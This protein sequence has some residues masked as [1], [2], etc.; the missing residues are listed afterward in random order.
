VYGRIALLV[1]LVFDSLELEELVNLEWQPGQSEAR[2][3]GCLAM[4]RASGNSFLMKTR[5]LALGEISK[6]F[7]MG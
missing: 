7:L 6:I 5:S 4:I 1:V 2:R 3:P